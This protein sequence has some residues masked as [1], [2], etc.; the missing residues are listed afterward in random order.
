MKTMGKYLACAAL[1]LPMIA[2]LFMMLSGS[3]MGV[4]EV[5]KS[6]GGVLAGGD[7]YAAWP[8]IPQ[9][10]T[11]RPYVELLIDSPEF[12][13][14]FW[15]SMMYAVVSLLGQALIATPAAW[16][17]AKY[18]FPGKN[19][20]LLIYMALMLMPFQ[21]TLVA[22]Y[23]SLDR[24]GLIDTPLAIILPL[25]FSTF[26]VFVMVKFFEAVPRAML[27]AAAIDGAGTLGIFRHVAL[28]LGVP[29]IMSAMVLGFLEVWGMIEQPMTLLKTPSYWPLSL[30]LPQIGTDSL[31][32]SLVASVVALAPALL[33]FFLGQQY[34][35]QGIGALG[36]KE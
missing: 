12:F 3:L 7:G 23:L 5:M 4:D 31:G 22:E 18:R 20:L 29:G 6:F 26:P 25:V 9:Y 34:L 13:S 36:M 32:K 27:E 14:M 21:V 11:A 19:L 10:V 33:V 35:E 1:A 17:L 8:L 15:N 24:F 30:Y 2:P 16:A 28:P